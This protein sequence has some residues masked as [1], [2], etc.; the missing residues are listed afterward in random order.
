MSTID[1]DKAVHLIVHGQRDL[2]DSIKNKLASLGFADE[3]LVPASLQKTGSVGEYV[4]MAWP[5]MRATEII[6][7]EITGLNQGDDKNNVMGAW[8]NVSQKEISRIP[9]S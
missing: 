7:S 3:K 9:L 6:L 8:S 2:I 1:Y 4:A 5:P